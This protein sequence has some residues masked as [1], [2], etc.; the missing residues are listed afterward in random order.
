MCLNLLAKLTPDY[1]LKFILHLQGLII[2]NL[3]SLHELSTKRFEAT[4]EDRDRSKPLI[5]LELPWSKP[6]ELGPPSHR[7]A[8]LYGCLLILVIE[9]GGKR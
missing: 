5:F 9:Q 7:N 6:Y 8:G 3:S 1:T 4:L 2:L